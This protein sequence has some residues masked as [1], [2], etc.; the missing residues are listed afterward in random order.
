[1]KQQSEIYGDISDM[2]FMRQ[3]LFRKGKSTQF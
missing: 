3:F 2:H 1:M